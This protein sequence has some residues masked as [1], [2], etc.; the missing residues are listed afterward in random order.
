MFAVTAV[1]C[2]DV[3][4]MPISE[5]RTQQPVFESNRIPRLIFH[6]EATHSGTRKPHYRG[7]TFA[8]R[9]TTLGRAPL[10]ARTAQRRELYLI[11]HNTH[12]R[13]TSMLSVGFEP[14]VPASER[15]RTHTLDRVV[16]ENGDKI[17]V[18]SNSVITS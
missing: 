2:F 3:C 10:D 5:L 1:G 6:G 8:L 11:T 9:H 4:F 18:Q 15:P 17:I 13:Q 14:A 12:N 16:T 7:F